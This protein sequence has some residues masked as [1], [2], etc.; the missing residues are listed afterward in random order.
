[1]R[2][3]MHN[4]HLKQLT[5]GT[6]LRYVAEDTWITR[7]LHAVVEAASGTLPPKYRKT[8]QTQLT[9]Y[10]SFVG[11]TG[12]LL[13]TVEHNGKTFAR[14]AMSPNCRLTLQAHC[15]ELPSTVVTRWKAGR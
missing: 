2:L 14:V 3:V 5:F 12:A 7:G 4:E 15:V 10:T 1:M 9:D 8:A 6:Q 11:H 13:G